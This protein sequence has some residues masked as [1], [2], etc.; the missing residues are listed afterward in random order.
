MPHQCVRCGQ[1]Y[2][3]GAKEILKGCSCGGK[4]F[5][6]IKKEKLKETKKII[7][8]ELDEKQKEQIEK[9]VMDLIGHKDDS[10]VI[11]D[12]ESIQV[13]EPGKYNIDIVQLFR[14]APVVFKLEEGKY[15]V[16]IA[17]SMKKRTNKE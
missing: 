9:D 4:L 17:E 14:G 10:P 5:F 15:I 16:D 7:P 6:F 1:I 13:S 12:L 3:D 2:D 8:Q 11:L